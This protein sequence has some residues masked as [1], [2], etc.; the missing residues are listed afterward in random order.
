MTRGTLLDLPLYVLLARPQAGGALS[1]AGDI[2]ELLPD[3]YYFG[4]VTGVLRARND[5]VPSAR[6]SRAISKRNVGER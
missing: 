2:H 4:R 6:I 1:L 3:A 5:D